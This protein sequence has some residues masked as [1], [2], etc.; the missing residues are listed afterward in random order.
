M[1][2]VPFHI[3]EDV[4]MEVTILVLMEVVGNTAGLGSKLEELHD[5]R[6]EANS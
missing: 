3:D 2:E 5:R 6:R 4:L 1:G